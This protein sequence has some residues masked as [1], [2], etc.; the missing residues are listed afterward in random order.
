MW[1]IKS[2]TDSHGEKLF[3]TVL[4][5]GSDSSGTILKD[6]PLLHSKSIHW[7]LLKQSQMRARSV[8]K[9]TFALSRR[10]EKMEF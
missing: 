1:Q 3:D 8:P 9:S 4:V 7:G 10:V 6:Q 2:I 5:N